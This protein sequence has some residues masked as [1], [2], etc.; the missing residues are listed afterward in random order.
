MAQKFELGSYLS[1]WKRFLFASATLLSRICPRIGR[2]PWPFAIVALEF[3]KCPLR[4]LIRRQFFYGEL[5]FF[6]FL[7]LSHLRMSLALN[8]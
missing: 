5:Q 8:R 3:T 2:C 1:Q 4:A 6:S 7:I